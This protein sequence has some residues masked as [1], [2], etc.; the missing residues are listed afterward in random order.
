[1]STIL[2]KPIYLLDRSKINLEFISVF[3]GTNDKKIDV[4]KKFTDV[5]YQNN[6]L[7]KNINLNQLFTDPIINQTK[8]KYL[9]LIN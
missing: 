1:M 9:L 2:N 5:F 4:L 7:P 6:K 8:K 3:Y